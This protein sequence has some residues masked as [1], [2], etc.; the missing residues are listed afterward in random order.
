MPPSYEDPNKLLATA[1]DR[2]EN[3]DEI[4]NHNKK[5]ILSFLDFLLS[6]NVHAQRIHKYAYTLVK[7]SKLLNKPFDKANEVD[8]QQLV[9]KIVTSDFSEWTK[10]EYKAVLKRFY[11]WLNKTG[12]TK[13]D[14]S[15]IKLTMKKNR[16]KLPGRF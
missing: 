14:L 5:L 16:A 2:V 13:L 4:P 10:H 9:K 12:K 3:D 15:W 6:D 8:I 1:K 7:I 11:G